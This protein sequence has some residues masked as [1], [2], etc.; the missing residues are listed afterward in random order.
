MTPYYIESFRN[1]KKGIHWIPFLFQKKENTLCFDQI[2]EA[3]VFELMQKF[4]LF[5]PVNKL[6]KKEIIV[7][8]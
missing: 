4:L 2:N 3:L 5:G 7:N 6:Y 8:H 1:I